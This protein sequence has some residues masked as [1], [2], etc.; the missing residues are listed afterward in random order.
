MFFGAWRTQDQS[1]SSS[2]FAIRTGQAMVKRALRWYYRREICNVK[3]SV[4]IFDF[5]FKSC[6][7][8]FVSLYA[9]LTPKAAWVNPTEKFQDLEFLF[10]DTELVCSLRFYSQFSHSSEK[11]R[12]ALN[13]LPYHTRV[14]PVGRVAK[15]NWLNYDMGM[16]IHAICDAKNAILKYFSLDMWKFAQ[17]WAFFFLYGE[18]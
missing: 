16:K 13:F 10:V 5:F 11:K 17:I 15:M 18:F 2:R 9:L 1:H 14:E 6:T 4:R 8:S 7:S 3:N 12:F